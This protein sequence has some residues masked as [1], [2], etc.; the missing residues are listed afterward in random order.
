MTSKHLSDDR[1]AFGLVHLIAE[2]DLEMRERA[3]HGRAIDA[4]DE[5]AEIREA[6]QSEATRKSAR[7]PFEKAHARV[8][9][10]ALQTSITTVH[11]DLPGFSSG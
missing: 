4:T 1:T 7:Q 2:G 9:R 5:R 11:E 8:E 6:V 10:K 3:A